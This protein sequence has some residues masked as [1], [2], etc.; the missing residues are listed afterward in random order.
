MEET[1]AGD[2]YDMPDNPEENDGDEKDEEDKEEVDRE[3]GLEEDPNEQVLVSYCFG[4]HF[5]VL[6]LWNHFQLPRPAGTGNH[7]SNRLV[8]FSGPLFYMYYNVP[9]G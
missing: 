3:M 2:M 4:E 5:D 1:F 7:P 9:V 6:G 8:D